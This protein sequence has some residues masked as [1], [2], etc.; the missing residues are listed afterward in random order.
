MTF[1]RLWRLIKDNY[2]DYIT[3]KT[4]KNKELGH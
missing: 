1:K 2:E 4:K 3:E